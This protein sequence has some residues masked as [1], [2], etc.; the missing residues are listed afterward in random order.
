MQDDGLEHFPEAGSAF[1]IGII[2]IR[3]SAMQLA[4][5]NRKA[6]SKRVLDR[7]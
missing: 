3:K 2:M 4:Q 7:F 5:V 6:F 1:N